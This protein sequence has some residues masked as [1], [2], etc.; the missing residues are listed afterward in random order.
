[1]SV[2]YGGDS[3][4]FA[5]SSTIS[6]GWTGFKNRVIN[7]AMVIDQ[8]NAGANTTV[9]AS[10]PYT[11]DRIRVQC[12]NHSGVMNV[13]QDSTTATGFVSSLRAIVTTANT[14]MPSAGLTRVFTN[15]EGNAISDLSW[16]TASAKTV[17]LSFWVR[18]SNTG[19]FSGS[20]TNYA[21]DRS[22]PF[23]YTINTANNWEYETITIPGDTSGN[24]PANTAGALVINFDLGS[25]TTQYGTANTW[26]AS[27]KTGVTGST[28]IMGTVG[29]NWYVTGI[30]LEKGSTASSFEYRPYGT[31]LQL[32]QRYY[33]V[34]YVDGQGVMPLSYAYNA[35]NNFSWYQFKCEKRATP[36]VNKL[37]GTWQGATAVPYPSLSSMTFY[38]SSAFYLSSQGSVNTKSFEI[39]SE[40]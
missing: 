6:S 3:I 10:A 18:S 20:I 15:L 7:G 34:I 29:N 12:A 8:R 38:A 26:A 2:S 33:E 37:S 31:E 28:S 36:T 30:Q 21:E 23:T 5:D 24:W 16:G 25:G 27:W 17:T 22:Y 32:C 13:R 1:M 40:L 9:S 11:V 14:S 19:T 4:T 35:G 39:V